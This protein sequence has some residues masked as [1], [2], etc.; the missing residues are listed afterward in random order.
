MATTEPETTGVIILFLI[1][2]LMARRTVSLAQGTPYSPTRV[3]GYGAFTMLIFGVFAAT[4][5]Y[6][7]LGVWGDLALA[8]VAPYLGVI[9]AAT[10]IA[11]PRVRARVRFERRGDQRLYYR[12]PI[13]I[14]VLTLALFVI[15]L[16]VEVLL[17]GLNA[18][19]TFSFPTS[20]PLSTLLVLIGVDLLYAISVGLLLGRGLAVRAAYAAGPAKDAPLAPSG[21]PVP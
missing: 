6:V 14:P 5:I 7:A 3:F 1:V 20:V 13:V 17:F 18:A 21:P 8:L 9:V 10:L 11:E 16:S 19:V 12:L 2:L 4:T 15:R